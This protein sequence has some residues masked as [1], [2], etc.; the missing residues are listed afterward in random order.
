TS[1]LD[2]RTE[3]VIVDNLRKR[4]CSCIFVAHRL[5]TIRDCD[6]IIVMEKG[7]VVQRGTH[8]QLWKEEGIYQGL[9]RSEG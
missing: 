1:A 4:K 8:K 5:S 7:K 6:E 2:A 3:Q 9:I